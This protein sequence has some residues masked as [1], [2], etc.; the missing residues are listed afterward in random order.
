MFTSLKFLLQTVP[1]NQKAMVF[2]WNKGTLAEAMHHILGAKEYHYDVKNKDDT[3]AQFVDRND[4]GVR[5]LLCTSAAGL[6]IDLP[7]VTLVVHFELPYSMMDYLQE[8]GRAG[9]DIS[10]PARCV[11]LRRGLAKSTHAKDLD[12][13]QAY[14]NGLGCR[15]Q[16]LD[17]VAAQMVTETCL[18]RRTR[19]ATVT[20][21][22]NCASGDVLRVPRDGPP[23]P[24]VSPEVY[25]TLIAHDASDNGIDNRA[26][27]LTKFR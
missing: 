18:A 5:V 12:A 3:M 4:H 23:L 20:C 26:D 24:Y 21:C 14:A 16:M 13:T 27:R 11:L 8:S 15:R 10:L 7:H 25:M 2:F 22:D 1:F 19:D 6:G 9:R 17:Y